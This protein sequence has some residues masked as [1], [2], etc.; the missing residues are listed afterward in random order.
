MRRTASDIQQAITGF[1]EL[2]ETN[3]VF[4]V[5]PTGWPGRPYDNAYGLR[6]S[7]VDPQGVLHLELSWGALSFDVVSTSIRFLSMTGRSRLRFES[8]P[9]RCRQAGAVLA[10]VAGR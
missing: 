1:F 7:A 8:V 5:L 9:A 3:A 6:S 10:L 4:I 2:F